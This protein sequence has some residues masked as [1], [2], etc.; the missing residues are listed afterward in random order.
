MAWVAVG[1][2]NVS[3]D[4]AVTVGRVKVSVAVGNVN[5]SVDVS[6]AV[7]SVNV[8]DAVGSVKVCFSVLTSTFIY[9]WLIGWNI[10]GEV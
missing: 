1:S 6:E 8:S 7:G 5:V 3:V 2:V 4:D 10:A 9:G